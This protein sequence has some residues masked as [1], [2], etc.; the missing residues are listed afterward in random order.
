MNTRTHPLAMTALLAGGLAWP[1]ADARAA[2]GTWA[3]NTAGG[4]WNVARNWTGNTIANGSGASA[5]F[6]TETAGV[7]TVT[8]DANVTL[9]VLNLSGGTVGGNGW[10]I[11][12]T[13]A[14]TLTLAGGTG[15]GPAINATKGGAYNTISVPVRGSEGLTKNG[16]GRLQLAGNNTY[17]GVT[18]VTDG[19]LQAN[20]PTALGLA[21]PGQE[22]VVDMTTGKFPQLHLN[23]GLRTGENII[24]R[25]RYYSPTAGATVGANLLY[26]DGGDNTVGA[27]LLDR[28]SASSSNNINFFGIQIAKGSLTISGPIRGQAGVSPASGAYPDPNVLRFRLTTTGAVLNAAGPISDGTIGTG[29]VSVQTTDDN[30]GTIR[31]SGDN[32]YGGSTVHHK[33]LLLVNNPTGSGTGSGPVKVAANAILGGTGIVAPGGANGVAFA[34]GAIL[35]PGDVDDGGASVVDGRPLTFNLAATTGEVVLEAGASITIDLG[36]DTDVCDRLAFVGL[37]G[38]KPRVQFR[39]TVVNFT[40]RGPVARGLYTIATFDNYDAYNAQLSI[41][42][43]LEGYTAS[44]QY[45]AKSIQLLVEGGP[46]GS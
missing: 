11:A 4:A 35:A 14:G 17:S 36:K 27:M 44:L 12:G 46:G 21:G 8:L 42:S 37:P 31:L 5:T 20:S 39:N 19:I 33:G 24:L 29:G 2:D 16:N 30:I 32:T 9:G 22:S 43:G 23:G 41:G 10:N 3:G 13:P 15:A 7:K 6:T 26:N 1:L 45:T 25:V 34:A 18:T 40:H 28:A 38:G